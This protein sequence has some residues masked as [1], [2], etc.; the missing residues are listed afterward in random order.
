MINQNLSGLG[1]HRST[2]E[3]RS[4]EFFVREQNL[5]EIYGYGDEYRSPEKRKESEPSRLGNSTRDEED[6]EAEIPAAISEDA[7]DNP[8]SV[9]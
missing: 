2:R 3:F 5:K 7:K 9:V 1:P 8:C 6:E 4:G